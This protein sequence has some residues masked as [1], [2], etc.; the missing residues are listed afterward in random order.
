LLSEAVS[1]HDEEILS[2]AEV[3]GL[4]A[5]LEAASSA[6]LAVSGGPDSTALLLMAAEWAARR[7]TT[8]I[9][10]ATVDHGLRPESAAEAASVARLCERLAVPH[11]TLVWAGA[12]P[13]TRVQER[14]REARYR[15]L[16][17]HAGAIGAGTIVTAHH[18]GD[19]AETVL[20]R[21]M[22][23]SGVAGLSGMAPMSERDGLAIAR[24]LL[25]VAKSTLVAFAHARG[26]AFVEDPSNADPRYARPRLRS[27]IAGLAAEGL[28]SEGLARLA[29]RA[30]EADEALERM[31]DEVESRLGANGPVDAGV[32]LAAPI[33]IVQRI[34]VRRIAAAGGRDP[35]RIGLEKIE[36]L[37][38]RLREASIRGQALGANVGGAV[39]QLSAKGRLS[40]A[41]EPA[42]GK[43]QS[44][45]GAVGGNCRRDR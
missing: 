25:S 30:A 11:R 10:A 34:L 42:R 26:A 36:A 43:R 9:A 39:A 6:L 14:A 19:Q 28:D 15:L 12:K 20:F 41:P 29:R 22:R 37:A 31:T 4:L 38:L 21:L 5:P 40:F 8:R 7:G 2:A 33:A 16:A 23:G 27:L 1:A 3:D 18:A 45:V 13:S 17:E 35:S 24:P 44:A 32:L